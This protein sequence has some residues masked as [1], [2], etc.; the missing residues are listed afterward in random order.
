MIIGKRPHQLHE[1][2]LPHKPEDVAQS[3]ASV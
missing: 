3:L 2:R 1:R